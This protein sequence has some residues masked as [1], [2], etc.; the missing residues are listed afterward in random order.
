VPTKHRFS[1]RFQRM[2]GGLKKAAVAS[3]ARDALLTATHVADSHLIQVQD[4]RVTA[5]LLQNLGPVLQALQP[6][7]DAVMRVGALLILKVDWAVYVHQLT[8]AQQA[9][10]DHRPDLAVTSPKQIITALELGL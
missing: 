5:N 6:S 1:V 9:V 10:L 2:T 7:K 3:A 8:A 4:A